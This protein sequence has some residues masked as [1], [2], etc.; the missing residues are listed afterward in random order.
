MALFL[1]LTLFTVRN[2]RFI[3]PLVPLG[4]AGKDKYYTPLSR[5]FERMKVT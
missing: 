4:E 3:I 1:S 2:V 5:F